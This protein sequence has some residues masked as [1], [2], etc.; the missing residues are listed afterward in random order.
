LDRK[1]VKKC[2]KQKGVIT[3]PDTYNFWVHGV[4]VIPEYQDEERGLVIQRAGWGARVAQRVPQ[5]S[6]ESWNWFHFAIP[7]PSML[8]DRRCYVE[9][10]WLRFKLDPHVTIKHVHVHR[11]DSDGQSKLIASKDNI[12]IDYTKTN[13]YIDFPPRQ[14]DG[15][16]VICVY[17]HFG[18]AGI[19]ITFIGAGGHFERHKPGQ[20]YPTD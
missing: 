17:V 15:A 9:G 4:S 13:V 11:A 10:V 2:K 18:L 6:G 8:N 14:C 1:V 5:Q 12:D 20:P 3:M 16:L 19:A 7:S